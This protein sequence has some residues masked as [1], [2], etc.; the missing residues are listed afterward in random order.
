MEEILVPLQEEEGHEERGGDHGHE[1]YPPTEEE[2]GLRDGDGNCQEGGAEH[3][4]EQ[5]NV[6]ETSLGLLLHD[7]GVVEADEEVAGE[8][9]QQEA[10]EDL[11][12][13][14]DRLVFQHCKREK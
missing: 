6:E 9:G 8:V 10:V 1:D 4:E 5:G 14:D 3:S 13:E 7:E 12:E 11:G 2:L